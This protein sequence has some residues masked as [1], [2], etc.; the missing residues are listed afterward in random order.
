MKLRQFS[1]NVQHCTV[2][3]ERPFETGTREFVSR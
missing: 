1:G 3:F 2:Q